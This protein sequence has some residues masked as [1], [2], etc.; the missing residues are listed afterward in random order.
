MYLDNINNCIKFVYHKYID[1]KLFITGDLNFPN[2]NYNLDVP[3]NV[4]NFD[5]KFIQCIIDNN[6]FQL[7]RQATRNN[8]I[9]EFSHCN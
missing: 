9:F 3:H 7:V 8:N 5:I 6:L 1:H 2:I 4:V